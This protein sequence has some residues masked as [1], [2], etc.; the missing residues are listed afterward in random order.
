VPEPAVEI[1]T[2]PEPAAGTAADRERHVLRDVSAVLG[3]AGQ[4][5][6][7]W[8][9]LAAALAGANPARWA[10]ADAD[11]VRSLCGAKHVPSVGV[12][13]AVPGQARRVTRRGCRASDV[14]AALRRATI[15]PVRDPGGDHGQ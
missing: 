10:G 9:E 14:R 15:T 2:E 4:P 6:I 7:W 1:D 13:R 5:G 8:P 3:A 11:E 12:N